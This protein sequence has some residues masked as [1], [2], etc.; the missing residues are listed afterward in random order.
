MM[1]GYEIIKGKLRYIHVVCLKYNISVCTDVVCT[2]TGHAAT[3]YDGN[4]IGWTLESLQQAHSLVD[5]RSMARLDENDRVG[6]FLV[7]MDVSMHQSPT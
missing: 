7:D 1:K 3:A 6:R 5:V 4:C 2:W